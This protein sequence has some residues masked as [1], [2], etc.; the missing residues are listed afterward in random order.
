M[1]T[2]NLN[3]AQFGRDMADMFPS[4]VVKIGLILLIGVLLKVAV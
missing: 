1:N 2:E 4:L 3:A